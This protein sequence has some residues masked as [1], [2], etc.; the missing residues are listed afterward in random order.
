MKTNTEAAPAG[1]KTAGK[2]AANEVDMLCKV[3]V[4]GMTYNG[5]HHAKDKEMPIPEAKANALVKLNPPQVEILG[6]V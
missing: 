4:N 6:V 2:P 5:A 3:L 1:E